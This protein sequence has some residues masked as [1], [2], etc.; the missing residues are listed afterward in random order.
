MSDCS[1]ALCDFTDISLE[2]LDAT[3]GEDIFFNEI[4]STDDLI[5]TNIE[6]RSVVPFSVADSNFADTIFIFFAEPEEQIAQNIAYNV[7]IEGIFD[8][9]L[10]YDVTVVDDPCCTDFRF[11]NFSIDGINFEN[12][13]A[14]SSTNS[15]VI[16]VDL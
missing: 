13:G 9:T 14:S 1:N 15:F 16:L 11:D 5:I 2:F 3:T 10:S 12:G 8:F 4:L 6:T 7:T